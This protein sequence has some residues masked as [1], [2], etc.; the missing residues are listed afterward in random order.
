[1]A[2]SRLAYASVGPEE[3]RGDATIRLASGRSL[4]VRDLKN[5][6]LPWIFEIYC[7]EEPG[8]RL[9]SEFL[10]DVGLENS[11]MTWRYWL[12]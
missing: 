12:D 4:V 6:G 5:D 10:E 2:L 9:L 11:N 3:S 1:M 8:E 7:F